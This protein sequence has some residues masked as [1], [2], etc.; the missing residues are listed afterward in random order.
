MKK[1]L[2]LASFVS[3]TGGSELTDQQLVMVTDRDVNALTEKERKLNP[4]KSMRRP[5]DHNEAAYDVFATWFKEVFPESTLK[6]VIIKRP[7]QSELFPSKEREFTPNEFSGPHS[8][9]E[10]VP[11]LVEGEDF[12]ETVAIDLTGE[13]KHWDFGWYDHTE[14]KWV[15]QNQGELFEN[16]FELEHAIWFATPKPK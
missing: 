1:L 4:E 15:M 12:S 14:R 5:F 3:E 7:I 8:C 9:K 11:P 16:A 10:S 2:F 13:M 6:H